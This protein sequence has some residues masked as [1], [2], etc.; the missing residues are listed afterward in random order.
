MIT[1]DQ[2][3]LSYCDIIFELTRWCTMECPH[4]IRGDKQRRRI[5]KEYIDQ[6]LEQIPTISTLMFS[7]GEPAL[8]VDLMEYTLEMV[9][10]HEIEVQNF[11]MATNG[12]ITSKKFFEVIKSWILACSDNE[13]SGLRVSMDRYHYFIDD[14]P[15]RMLEDEIHYSINENFN[16]EYQGAPEEKYLIGEGRAK[17]NYYTTR[18]ISHD[19]TL[20]N[21]GRIEGN[22]YITA[23]G[24]L[25]S[26]CDISFDT[27]DNNSDFIICHCTE[28]I[29]AGL[30]AWFNV[31]PDQVE[32]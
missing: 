25:V 9:G 2:I 7:G 18:T 32:Q 19:I 29:K 3:D 31:H 4:C 27:M 26:S 21:D 5:K 23:K 6:T 30:A 16:F 15:F 28:D 22:L 1:P 11:W 20:Q 17:E 8:A 24:Y 10:L 14:E 12:D 13:V